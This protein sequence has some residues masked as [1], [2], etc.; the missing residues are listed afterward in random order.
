MNSAASERNQERGLIDPNQRRVSSTASLKRIRIVRAAPSPQGFSVRLILSPFILL[1][2]LL[3]LTAC[4]TSSRGP[5]LHHPDLR[6]VNLARK[7]AG[8]HALFRRYQARGPSQWNQGWPWQLDLSGVAWDRSNTA[9]AITPRHVVMAA[10][11]SRK[12]GQ[13]I[14]FHDRRGN[15]HARRMQRTISLRERGLPADVAVGLLDKALPRKVRTYPLPSPD[16]ALPTRLTGRLALVTEQKRRLYFHRIDA[17][18]NGF[19]KLGK[20]PELPSHAA[21][22]LIVGDSG[23]PSF[24]LSRGE[25]ILIE[26]HTHGGAGSGPF[27]GA[28][29]VQMKIREILAELDSTHE[30]RTVS[31]H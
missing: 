3:G 18:Q 31:I 20:D 15:P 26:T 23:H 16:A 9:T 10:H 1:V 8:D 17:I 5:A 14:I 29:E 28:S 13:E 27:Y 21:K 19:L 4:S 6:L 7:P 25:L 11:Y 12:A 2:A 30:F 22:N 24:V